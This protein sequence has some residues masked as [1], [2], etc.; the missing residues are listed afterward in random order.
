[1][2]T[3]DMPEEVAGPAV[4]LPFPAPRAIVTGIA[5]NVVRSRSLAAGKTVLAR[6]MSAREHLLLDRGVAPERVAADLKA[7]V[8]RVSDAVIDRLDDHRR[9]LWFPEGARHG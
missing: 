6:A 7:T 4:I 1:M 3:F 2:S 9:A 8:A 5:E